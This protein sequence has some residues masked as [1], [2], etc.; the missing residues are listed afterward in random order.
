[1]SI[2]FFSAF[3]S[4]YND[5]LLEVM[6]SKVTLLGSTT[7][8]ALLFGDAESATIALSSLEQF[9]DIRYAQIYDADRVLFAEYS[10]PGVQ[11]SKA[12]DDF[13]TDDFFENQFKFIVI[14]I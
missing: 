6:R 8:S 12:I 1:M 13:Q 4:Y 9:E 10:R 14:P 5:N 7:T 3:S 11:I 2:F